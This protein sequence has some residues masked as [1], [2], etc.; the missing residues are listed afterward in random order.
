MK[1]ENA[2]KKLSRISAGV[3][4]GRRGLHVAHVRNPRGGEPSEI[5]FLDQDGEVA[6]IRIHT[7]NGMGGSRC[8]NISRAISSTSSG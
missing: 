2:I 7:V 4:E 8:D 3:V 1:T 5:S 6:C